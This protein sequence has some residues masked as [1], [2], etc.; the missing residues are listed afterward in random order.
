MNWNIF[1]KA[2]LKSFVLLTCLITPTMV[3]AAPHSISAHGEVELISINQN[4]KA[5]NLSP[6]TQGKGSLDHIFRYRQ[7]AAKKSPSVMMF[8]H[9]K[10]LE[11]INTV[12]QSSSNEGL[13]EKKLKI[14]SVVSQ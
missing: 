4:R 3:K 12:K 14:K 10:A 7:S 6:R 9:F 2:T 11:R 8:E 5:E 1:S 13:N